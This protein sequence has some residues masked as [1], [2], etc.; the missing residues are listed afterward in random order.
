[1]YKF[2]IIGLLVSLFSLRLQAQ[3]A[4]FLKINASLLPKI[5]YQNRF[6]DS[7]QA[8]SEVKKIIFSLHKQGFLLASADTFF[9]KKDT[10]FADLYIGKT[11]SWARL[12]AGNVPENILSSIGFREKLYRSEIFSYRTVEKM[13]SKILQYAENHG[14]PFAAVHID[15]VTIENENIS[16][17][18]HYES[19]YFFVFDTLALQGSAKVK[20]KFL[21]A[22][23][24]LQAGKVFS[25]E[26]VQASTN[27]L[28]RLPYLAVKQQVGVIFRNDKA[29]PQLSIDARKAN[30][31]DGIIGFLPNETQNNNRLLITGE[32]NLQLHNLF[33]TGKFFKLNWQQIKP[34][35]PIL[36]IVYQHPALFR[37]Q[38]SL[39]AGLNLLKQD[40]N[41]I[42]INRFVTL[43]QAFSGN[44]KV[45]FSVNL[46]NTNTLASNTLYA[47]L[48][49]LPAVLSTRLLSYGLQFSV[50]TTDD[51][52][53]PKK[54][55]VAHVSAQAGNKNIIRN[56]ALK[57]ELYVNLPESSL[58]VQTKAAAIKYI[59][60]G[61]R[62]I[63]V[64]KSEAG[65]IWNNY[66]FENELFRLGGLNSIRGF[67][68]NT[69]FASSFAMFTTE[70]RFFA[71]GET[72]FFLFSDGAFL[73]YKVRQTSFQ[74]TPLGIGAG[75][76]F[77]TKT[78]IF[79]LVYAVGRS[80]QQVFSLNFSKIHFGF[81]SR[82]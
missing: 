75:L 21:A 8:L 73:T 62:G 69:F 77:T 47:N 41:F 40:T 11:F 16:G 13:E 24:R 57:P 34:L 22:Y 3:K 9:F 32:L 44:A 48:Q 33:G 6:T 36:G 38:L 61:K 80:G 49:T 58:Q 25:Q 42:N 54:G 52:F 51:V 1:M 59:R 46:Q 71:E 7:L 50:N 18:L 39:E 78:G 4:Y 45:G 63:L 29:I 15:S 81:V 23:L 68:E 2:L 79:N 14:F 76:S 17:T 70:Y 37:T 60:A 31:F 64:L 67:N 27:A 65:K 74:D 35:S 66:L 10:L 30:Q 53:Y 82:F 55:W 72:Y 26:K 56:A 12:K 20:T 5:T 43:S 28:K 19:G